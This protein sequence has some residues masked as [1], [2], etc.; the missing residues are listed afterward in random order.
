[1]A[2]E[3]TNAIKIRL[4]PL[5]SLN[6]I[7]YSLIIKQQNTMKFRSAREYHTGTL[8]KSF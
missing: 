5:L 3:D 2:G 8:K 1:V 7:I 6:K 4:K